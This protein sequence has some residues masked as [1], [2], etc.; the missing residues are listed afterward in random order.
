VW[1]VS[2]FFILCDEWFH[3]LRSF[4]Y[5]LT[6]F[7]K[8][9]TKAG[10]RQLQTSFCLKPVPES[11]IGDFQAKTPYVHRIYMVLA[12]PKHFSHILHVDD[13]YIFTFLLT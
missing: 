2:L 8:F 12:N 1:L 13:F 5:L 3:C 6:S 4:F 10:T 7:N 11:V 9:A